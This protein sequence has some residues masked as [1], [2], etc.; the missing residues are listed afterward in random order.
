MS[1]LFLVYCIL[2]I[3]IEAWFPYGTQQC[4]LALYNYNCL[5]IIILYR[6]MYVD[7]TNTEEPYV[8]TDEGV[9]HVIIGMAGWPLL[10]NFE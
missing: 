6:P 9:R 10:Q 4:F 3:T 2:G 7:S 1:S 5:Q 8:C